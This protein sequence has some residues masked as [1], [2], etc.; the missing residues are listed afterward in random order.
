MEMTYPETPGFQKGSET[1]EN[2]AHSSSLYTYRLCAYNFL[3]DCGGRGA[4]AKELARHMTAVYRTAIQ[5]TTAGARLTE[6]K[7]QGKAMQA[8]HSREGS[9][10]IILKEF[11]AQTSQ[12]SAEEKYE[13]QRTKLEKIGHGHVVARKDGLRAGCGG[14]VFCKVCAMEKSYLENLKNK[15]E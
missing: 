10:V 9:D 8:G 2:A 13:N 3:R 6:L 1:S 11:A 14:P 4:T 15:G 12:P 5:Y 7:R